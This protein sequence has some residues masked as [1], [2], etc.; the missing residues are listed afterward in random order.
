[1]R[2]VSVALKK[3]R[4]VFVLAVGMASSSRRSEECVSSVASAVFKVVAL[5]QEQ[6]DVIAAIVCDHNVIEVLPT[7]FGKSLCYQVGTMMLNGFTQVVTPL[8]ALCE[9]QITFMTAHN[10][11]VV[12]MD[13]TLDHTSQKSICERIIRED[14]DL[15]AV[16]TTPQTLKH[17][18]R[19]VRALRVATDAGRVNF[20][21]I[22]A[23][24]CVLDW[25][26]FM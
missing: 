7:G 15:K 1:M 21:T 12:R 4:D 18:V 24:H 14:C 6:V 8:L 26:D 2:S 23:A 22:D 16:Y 5:R 11:P 10:V 17:N 9:D 19:V 25:S 3:C 13:S 20:A